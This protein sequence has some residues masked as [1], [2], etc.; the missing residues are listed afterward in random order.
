MINGIEL[1]IQSC[2]QKNSKPEQYSASDVIFNQQ[3]QEE[4][5]PFRYLGTRLPFFILTVL[6]KIKNILIAVYIYITLHCLNVLWMC[7][8]LFSSNMR[9]TFYHER[10]EN[11]WSEDFS[12]VF[13]DEGL[14]LK[15][16][17]SVL[18]TFYRNILLLLMLFSFGFSYSYL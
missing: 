2:W 17:I 8:T 1:Q 5:V 14:A 12:F 6:T 18:A 7:K 16:S 10:E 13:A 9:L 15:R 3:E 4:I 11:I